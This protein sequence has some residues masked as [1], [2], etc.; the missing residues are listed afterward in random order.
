M[1]E[2]VRITLLITSRYHETT[3]SFAGWRYRYIREGD[4][5]SGSFAEW[6]LPEYE[7][8]FLIVWKDGVKPQ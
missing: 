3:S 5:A 7:K 2:V 8:L 4:H 6:L 1:S